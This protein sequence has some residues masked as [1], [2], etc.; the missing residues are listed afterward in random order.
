VVQGEH[1]EYHIEGLAF[2]RQLFARTQAEATVVVI[3]TDDIRAERVDPALFLEH[4]GDSHRTAAAI[5]NGVTRADETRQ[6]IGDPP[7]TIIGE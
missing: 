7:G 4:P 2:E 5:E 3:E 1:Q 6:S